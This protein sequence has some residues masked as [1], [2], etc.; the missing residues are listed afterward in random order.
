MIAGAFSSV[1]GKAD[2]TLDTN[3]QILY[4]NSG[5]QASNIGSEG[6][7]LTVSDADLP[8]WETASSG[9][10]SPLTANL[11][12]NDSIEANFGTGGTDSKIYHDGSNW[13]F[14]PVTGYIICKGNFSM[15]AASCLALNRAAATIS[16]GAITGTCNT[17][18]VSTEGGVS[19]DDLDAGNFTA[20]GVTGCYFTLIAANDAQTVV[21]KDQTSGSGQFLAAGDF[22]LDNEMDTIYFLADSGQTHNS[23]ISRSSNGT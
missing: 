10:S 21:V 6:K 13:Y 5:R 19:S 12:W 15:E 22:S 11:V 3:G 7:V 20:A 4:Y 23:E 17:M 2:K 9:L 8:A 18:I 14:D 1:S 16:A